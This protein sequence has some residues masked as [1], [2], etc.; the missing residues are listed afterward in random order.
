MQTRPERAGR[1]KR[2][3]C[4]RISAAEPE[5]NRNI[6]AKPSAI[7]PTATAETRPSFS[8]S[9]S[10]IGRPQMGEELDL[11]QVRGAGQDHREAPDAHAHAAAG[12]HAV[13][14]REQ[15]VL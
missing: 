9:A 4:A 15:E 11:A 14:E 3:K 13:L 1:A 8:T 12:R 5:K 6:A 7:S 10:S 2:R